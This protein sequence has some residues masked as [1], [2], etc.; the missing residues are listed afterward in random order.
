MAAV[1]LFVGCFILNLFALCFDSAPL[2]YAVR[3]VHGCVCSIC[4]KSTME[5]NRESSK[6]RERLSNQRRRTTTHHGCCCKRFCWLVSISCQFNRYLMPPPDVFSHLCCYILWTVK[7][8]YRYVILIWIYS[9]APYF[10]WY[11]WRHK[12]GQQHKN[13]VLILHVL[14]SVIRVQFC[15]CVFMSKIFFVNFSVGRRKLNLR[16]RFWFV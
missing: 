11:S 14:Q 8:R 12:N 10:W 9:S 16:K 5:Q 4:P 3:V 2:W 15:V 1:V 13:K 7:R 6:E